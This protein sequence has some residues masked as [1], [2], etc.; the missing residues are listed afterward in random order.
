M[1]IAINGLGRIGKLVFRHLI[2]K[3]LHK[4]LILINE[5][6]GSVSEN[7]HLI[8]YDSIHGMWDKNVEIEANEIKFKNKKIKFYNSRTIENIPLRKNKI[9]LVIDC[10][11][12]F[13]KFDNISQYF[14]EGVKKV[15]ISA[16]VHDYRAL[17]LVYGIN[18][19]LLKNSDL[20]IITGA[21]CTTNCLAPII[22]VIEE[23][24]GII[25]G[26]ITTIHNSTNSQTILDNPGTDIR[27]SRSAFNSLIPT[28][29]GSAR[30][31]SLI[32]PNL[33]S[34]LD[35]YAVR[36]PVL[37]SSLTDCVFDLKK[38]TS[39]EEVNNY[40]KKASKT[41][42]K[43]ILD[44]E[45]KPL[46]SNDFVNNPNSAIIDGTST[47]VINKKMLKVYAWYDNEWAYSLRLIDLVEMI[48]E[49]YK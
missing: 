10:T 33:K 45:E 34:K 6:N 40:F 31:I 11:G 1:R 30:A 35:G 37:N 24:L 38:S 26:S 19:Y 23:N 27:R 36:V 9:D 32:Y 12:S 48:I 3:K 39:R 15:L 22:K 25:R 16:P 2:D 5:K 29:T 8:K 49:K 43:G 20:D 7:T 18:S 46:V 4:K 28:S 42:L 47:M 14:K 44:F 13:K 17:N 21:S 41:Y